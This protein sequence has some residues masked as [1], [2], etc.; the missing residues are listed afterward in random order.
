VRPHVA[1]FVGTFALVFFGCGA[2]AVQVLAP[3]GVALAF[4]LAIAVGIYGLGHVSGAHVNPAV[5]VGFAI[6]RG[7]GGCASLPPSEGRCRR[8]LGSGLRWLTGHDPLMVSGVEEANGAR[9]SRLKASV[10][11][12]TPANT[13]I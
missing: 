5:S 9:P 4:G 1:E 2:I 12:G 11:G 10:P 13:W 7:D 3:T 8:S 6:G